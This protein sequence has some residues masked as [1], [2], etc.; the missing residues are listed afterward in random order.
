MTE[1]DCQQA[2]RDFV[3]ALAAIEQWYIVRKA[4]GEAW[5]KRWRKEKNDLL[6]AKAK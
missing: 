4:A 6:S 1:R 5:M 2:Y 3:I